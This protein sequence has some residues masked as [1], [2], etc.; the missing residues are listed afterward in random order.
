MR[1]ASVGVALVV[2]LPLGGGFSAC[3]DRV[4]VGYDLVESGAPGTGGSDSSGGSGTSGGSSA[5]GGVLA[6]T[7]GASEAGTGGAAPAE[8]QTVAC[9]GRVL[10]CGNCTDDDADGRIDALDPECLGPCDDSEASLS[11]GTPASDNCRLDCAFDRDSGGGNDRCLR[12]LRCDELSPGASA[13]CEADPD[14]V[15]VDICLESSITQPESCRLS[16]EPL[17]PNGCD[18]FGCCELPAR[19]GNYVWIGAGSTPME[20]CRVDRLG[21]AL[22]CPP[23]TPVEACGN[24]CDDCE[25][26]VGG[27]GPSSEC[28]TPE[29]PQCGADTPHCGPGAT[30]PRDRYCVTGCC[31]IVPT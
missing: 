25:S 1:R 3:S 30:C 7:G 17:T 12:D 19:S 24:G 18:C 13:G 31:I 27:V 23:C 16:C 29:T 21:D 2:W 14:S 4:E 5:S 26:C 28:A 6:G 10:E 22:A 8:C 15:G 11:S 20:G 9:R